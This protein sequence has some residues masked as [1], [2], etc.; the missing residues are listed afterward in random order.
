MAGPAYKVLERVQVEGDQAIGLM[1]E[2][3]P[4]NSEP[5]NAESLLSPR[6]VELCFQTAGIWE[7]KTKRHLALPSVIGSLVVHRSEKDASG[8][9][10]YAIV[11]AKQGGESF[12]ARVADE[13]GRLFVELD[14]YRTI[15]FEENRELPAPAES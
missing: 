11:E 10:L 2:D 13:T 15:V 9:R 3:L 7:V 4:P 6:L 1:A 12:E 5:A 8:K 14:G